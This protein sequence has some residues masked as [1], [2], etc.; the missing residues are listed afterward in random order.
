LAVEDAMRR[1]VYEPGPQL[2]ATAFIFAPWLSAFCKA[3]STKGANTLAWERSS[4]FTLSK[5]TCPSW[6]SA[7]EQVSVDASICNM[8][9]VILLLLYFFCFLVLKRL[10]MQNYKLNITFAIK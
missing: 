6:L 9:V 10:N 1:L 4:R 3:S 5:N 7:T 2:S 8:I